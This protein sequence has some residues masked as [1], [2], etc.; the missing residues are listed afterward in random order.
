MK[1]LLSLF[2]ALILFSAAAT[3]AEAPAAG[4]PPATAAPAPAREAEIPAALPAGLEKFT[5]DPS[6][7]QVF[8]VVNHLGF[9]HSRGRFTK[10]DGFFLLDEKNPENSKAEMTIDVNSLEMGSPIWNEH[11]QAKFLNG[12]I[13]PLIAFHSTKIV[14]T[15]ET[16]ADMT[17]ELSLHGVTKPVTLQVTLNK[18]GEHP[19]NKNKMAGFSLKGTLKRSDFGMTEALPMIGDDVALEI[20]V[21]GIRQDFEKKNK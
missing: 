15:G 8:F 7:T 2:F 21:E 18:L 16:T 13:H 9:S 14:R 19:M 12:G 1:N 4:A 20:E 6:H 17:G 10:F 11:T 3:A 5:Y